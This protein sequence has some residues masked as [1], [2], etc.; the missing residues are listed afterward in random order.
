M[1]TRLHRLRKLFNATSCKFTMFTAALRIFAL[2]FAVSAAVVVA[3]RPSIAAGETNGILYVSAFPVTQF[4]RVQD[5]PGLVTVYIFHVTSFSALTSRFRLASSPGVTMTY[6]SETINMPLH[7]GGTQ[8][9]ITICYGGCTAYQEE[10]LIASITYMA[11]GTGSACGS[12]K[13]VPHP[14]AQTVDSVDC[15]GI[16]QVVGVQDASVGPGLGSCG[17]PPVHVFAG[18]PSY[19]TCEPVATSPSTWGAIKALYRD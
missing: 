2:K 14:D 18:T 19:A 6:V 7:S 1:T 12:I 10:L 5:S 8:T 16:P 13:V 17:C 4:C 11:Y 15:A 9:G 3:L